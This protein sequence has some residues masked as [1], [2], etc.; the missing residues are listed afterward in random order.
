MEIGKEI[1]VKNKVGIMKI[2][3]IKEIVQTTDRNIC[4]IGIGQFENLRVEFYNDGKVISLYSN[5][6]DKNIYFIEVP[7]LFD[8]LKV[9]ECEIIGGEQPEYELERIEIGNKYNCYLDNGQG[10]CCGLSAE[11]D[12]EPIEKCKQCLYFD[13]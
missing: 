8:N 7:N 10:K 3:P 11:F 12:D 13:K 9:Y 1:K 4:N 2:M 5:E 6:M